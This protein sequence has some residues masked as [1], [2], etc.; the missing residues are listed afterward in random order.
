MLEAIT[1]EAVVICF[2][3]NFEKQAC[4]LNVSVVN[5]ICIFVHKLHT[6]LIMLI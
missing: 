6:V 1:N 3:S 4:L 2:F 5:T